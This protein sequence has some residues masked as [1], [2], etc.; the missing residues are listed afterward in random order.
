MSKRVF[1]LGVAIYVV[2]MA[3]LLTDRLL[4]ASGP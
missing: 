4:A 2:A 1:L 3:F